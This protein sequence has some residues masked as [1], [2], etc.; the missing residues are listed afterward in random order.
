MIREQRNSFAHAQLVLPIKIK[1]LFQC[2]KDVLSAFS[3]FSSCR[4]KLE[5]VNNL[6]RAFFN[7]CARNDRL[8]PGRE[9]IVFVQ[10]FERLSPA[11]LRLFS[12]TPQHLF[13]RDRMIDHIVYVLTESCQRN[14]HAQV[15]LHGPH[16]VGKTLMMKLVAKK[17]KHLF[18]KQ[19]LLQTTAADALLADLNFFLKCASSK[20]SCREKLACLCTSCR[21]LLLVD[22]MRSVMFVLSL[23]P[24]TDHARSS[25]PACAKQIGKGQ[26]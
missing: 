25:S 24:Q 16:G 8:S 6:T 12:S 4:S 3:E 9:S 15:L 22:D 10:Y 17:T 2:S 19:C 23:L 26:V 11:P 7:W 14:E 13:G 1:Q 18:D 21:V 20:S 5:N